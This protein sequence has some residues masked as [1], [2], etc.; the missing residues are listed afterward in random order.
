VSAPKPNN[1]KQQPKAKSIIEMT[2]TKAKAFFLK[3]ESYCNLDFP[4]YFQFGHLITNAKVALGHCAISTVR[5]QDPRELEGLNYTI[6]NN[7]DGRHAWRAFQL[8]HPALYVSLVNSITEQGHWDLICKR[9][10]EF[11]NCGIRCLS[12]PV[13]SKS[14]ERDKAEQIWQWWQGIEQQ[15]IE[16][17][18]DYE[19]IVHADITDCYGAIYTHS[20]AWALHGKQFAKDHR[21]DRT[22]IG[23]IIDNHLQDMQHGQTNGI[24]QG[25]VV[26]D[27]IA[28]I[29]LGY[30]DLQLTAK[31][32]EQD[33]PPH[34]ML[35]YRDDYR[36]LTNSSQ[37][38][39]LILKCL[40]EVLI[41][42]GLRLNS[43]KTK[44]SDDV[45][46]ASLK[47]DKLAWTRAK[48]YDRDLEKHLLL[49]HSHGIEFPNA[50]SVA[51]AL[52]DFHR[53]VSGQKL[54]RHPMP[55]ISIC[56]DIAYRNPRTYPVCAA[57]VS[58]LLEFVDSQR[59]EVVERIR[60]RFAKLPNTG[61]MEV[62]LQRISDP[63]QHNPLFNEPLCK[64]VQGE[65]VVLWNNDWISSEALKR[66]VEPTMILN[67]HKAKNR[68]PVIKPKE[69]EL[70]K[71][72]DY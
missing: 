17:A 64:L 19:Y 67:R 33:A 37:D 61:Y 26:M 27:F 36:I 48:T 34:L 24:P 38:A 49:I 63:N 16:L 41:E 51:G 15:S 18:L 28:E 5:S 42:L 11:G 55:L 53:R 60:A 68:K 25:S 54:I 39:D 10:K 20:I 50:G 32:K 71:P 22:L 3:H 9:F 29:V 72:I 58:T 43:S 46:R 23:N 47:P 31:L 66:A 70:F 13:E 65:E 21:R 30:S 59:N 69:V 7:K 4:P 45:V 35:R 14:K 2:A 8:I 57:I 40:T 56:I 62:W 6:L 1:K 52:S 44:A 12:L